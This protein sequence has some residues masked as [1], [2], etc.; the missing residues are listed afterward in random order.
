MLLLGGIVAPVAR[1]EAQDT[2]RD[3]TV[4]APGRTYASVTVGISATRSVADGVLGQYWD[5]G[6]GAR[7]DVSAPFHVGDVGAFV[8]TLPYT[9]RST[10]QP[11]FRAF[12]IGLDWRLVAPRAWP[13]RPSIGLTA[14]DLLT[15]FD[16]VETKGLSKESE[17]F[18]GGTAGLA[19][20]VAG[21]TSVT[22]TATAIQVLTST[23]IRTTSVSVG[24]A[25]EFAT[26]G[27][28]RGVIE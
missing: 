26:P 27:W 18:L 8:V 12:V 19:V 2:T 28:L 4:A 6:T 13:V 20:R 3:T 22:A 5:A 25:H 11:D 23:P 24:L 1:T 16:G 14:G 21:R 17:I 9:A 10:S 7:V 15:T